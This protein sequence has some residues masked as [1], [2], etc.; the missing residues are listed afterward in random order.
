MNPKYSVGESIILQ[1]K[2]SPEWNGECTVLQILQKGSVY[3]CRNTSHVWIVEDANYLSYVL[4]I[5]V[6]DPADG[7]E[8]VWHELALRKKHEPSQMSFQSLI[9]SV[10]SPGSLEC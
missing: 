1:S 9:Q 4:D 6:V 2:D 8:V 5:L 10:N 3:K 7:Y